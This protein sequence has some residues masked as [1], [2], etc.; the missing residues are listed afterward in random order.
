MKPV[1]PEDIRVH[2]VDI[3]GRGGLVDWINT[4]LRGSEWTEE[5]GRDGRRVNVEQLN[6]RIVEEVREVYCP[7]GWI[8]KYYHK[9]QRQE[10]H[11]LFK[12]P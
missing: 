11:F 12:L 8:V 6:D 4:R 9:T 1:R 10:S 3:H 5:E 2:T 7:S